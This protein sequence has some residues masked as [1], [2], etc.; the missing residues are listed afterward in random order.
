MRQIADGATSAQSSGNTM[1]AAW[2]GMTAEKVKIDQVMSLAD[3][4]NF[5]RVDITLTNQTGAAMDNV[6]YMRTIDPDHGPS[7]TTINTIIEQGGDGADGALIAAYAAKGSTPFFYYSADDRA[8]VSTY[9]LKNYDPYAAAA[10]TTAQSEGFSKA[11]DESININFDIGTLAAGATTTV[12]FYFGI[13]DNLNTTISTIKSHDTSTSTPPP[14]QVPVN[15]APTVTNDS[16]STTGTAAA[17]GNVLA[18]DKDTDGDALTA[19]LVK[20]PTHGTLTFAADGSYSYV[21]EKGYVGTDNFTYA[22]SDGKASANATVAINVAAVPN[23]TPTVANDA[24]STTGTAPATGNVLANDKDTDGDALTASLVKGPTHGTLTFAADGSYSYVAEKGYVGTD[25]FTYAASDGKASANATVA[26]N[27]AAVPNSTP[28]VANDAASTT[29]TAPATGNV[30]ANDKDTDGDALTASLVK[31]PTHGTLTFAADGSY[32]YVAEKG[33]VGTDNFTYAASDGKASANATVAINV[34][35]VP[36]STPTVAN[37]AASTTGTAPAT[38]N[39]LANDKD[40]DGDALTA[41]LVKG[42][43]HGT[44]TFAADGS[45][46]YVAEKGYV[47]T[48]NFTYAASDGKASA[49]ATVAIDVNAEVIVKV[50]T[51]VTLLQNGSDVANQL[52]IATLGHDV[53]YFDNSKASGIDTIQGV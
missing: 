3:D 1:T 4:A 17:T 31:G 18:N 23:S 30:L 14:V 36:N 33:Y 50:P 6:R 35:A 34:A 52:L 5:V 43:T 49:N 51:T 2:N 41:S 40:T 46:S 9:G 25:N 39:V 8:K 24:A 7:F 16:A 53:F 38:G 22:A 10:Y 47:G 44:L 29:G 13:T 45:Y 27:V 15:H 26:I 11:A 48:D 42:P 12:T 28:T 19:S 32:S 21:A 20:G 37:D